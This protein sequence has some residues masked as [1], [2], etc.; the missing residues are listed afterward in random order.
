MSHNT[1]CRSSD[2]AWF[3]ELE[4][5]YLCFKTVKVHAGEKE[6]AG[7][8]RSALR[9]GRSHKEY[10]MTLY[11]AEAGRNF[12]DGELLRTETDLPDIGNSEDRKG[13]K[14]Q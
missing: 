9:K 11:R 4:F 7:S 5:L 3:L 8:C 6:K 10:G 2:L 12:D 14:F 13:W 1:P